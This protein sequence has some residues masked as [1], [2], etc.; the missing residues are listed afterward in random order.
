MY[1][2]EKNVG[3][4]KLVNNEWQK[5]KRQQHYS[6]KD[7]V[8]VAASRSHNSYRVNTFIKRLLRENKTVSAVEVGS[9]L[10]LCL[11]AENTLDVYPR[12]G[13]TMEWDIAAGHAIIKFAGGEVRD[14]KT[15][16]PLVYNKE[17]LKNP[18][19]IAE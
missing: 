2:G 11:L 6:E 18:H 5:I 19:F 3:S 12:Y 13:D 9:S 15:Q 17:N 14:I 1:V 16:K 7:K 10:K 4:F 8:I